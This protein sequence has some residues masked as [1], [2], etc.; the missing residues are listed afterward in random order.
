MKSR[1]KVD[2]PGTLTMELRGAEGGED[3]RKGEEFVK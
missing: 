3:A 1:R 2:S